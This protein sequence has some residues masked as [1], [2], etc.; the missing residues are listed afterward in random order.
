MRFCFILAGAILTGSAA[1]GD[2]GVVQPAAEAA[3]VVRPDPRTGRLVRRV[4]VSPRVI[5]PR[6]VQPV[7]VN[8]RLP[9]RAGSAAAPIDEIVREVALKH[10]VDP[11]LVHSV[12]HVESR[13][14]PYAISPKGAEGIMQLLPSTARRF[15]VAN[16]FNPRDNIEGGVRYLRYLQDLFRNDDR[17]V[18]A[19]YNAGEGAVSRYNWIPPYRETLDYVV[20]VG[21]KLGQL[22]KKAKGEAARAQ[23]PAAPPV[24]QYRPLEQYVDSEGR[25]HLRTR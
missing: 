18:L 23:P 13:F 2:A 8:S 17:L 5:S 6:V 11:L 24:G 1:A 21:E 22:R 12:I 25:L 9:Q 4:V 14:N 19:A 7:T 3:S 15:G 10:Q 16:T 20:R